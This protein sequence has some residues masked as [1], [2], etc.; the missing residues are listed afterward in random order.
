MALFGS[1]QHEAA[2]ALSGGNAC[3]DWVSCPQLE[4]CGVI[5]QTANHLEEVGGL[6]RLWRICTRPVQGPTRHTT[7]DG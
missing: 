4:F 7:L 2:K 3:Y 5:D 1:K 6:M